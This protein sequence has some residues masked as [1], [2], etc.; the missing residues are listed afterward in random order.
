MPEGTTVLA[1]PDAK[2]AAVDDAPAIDAEKAAKIIG[3]HGKFKDTGALVAGYAHVESHASRVTAENAALKERMA[4]LEQ[5]A[6]LAERLDKLMDNTT[7][8]PKETTVQTFEEFVESN[9]ERWEDGGIETAVSD[10]ARL[11]GS[12]NQH[13]KSE[14][15]G[16]VDKQIGELKAEAAALREAMAKSDTVYQQNAPRVETLVKRGMSLEAAK[17]TAAEEAEERAR[18]SSDTMAAPAGLG[19]GRSAAPGGGQPAG[20]PYYSADERAEMKRKHGFD[21]AKMDDMERR[22]QERIKAGGQGQ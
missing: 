18:L 4:Q 13:T 5:N 17:A 12:W 9:K 1:A 22:A 6:G 8:K 19:P 11:V 10:M 20:Q 16:L 14:I 21:D 7:P 15:T 3:E 2:G